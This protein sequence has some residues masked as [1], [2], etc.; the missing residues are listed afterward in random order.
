MPKRVDK[1][2]EQTDVLLVAMRDAWAG[3][4]GTPEEAEDK[5]F[6][7]SIIDRY[8][9]LEAENSDLRSALNITEQERDSLN[10]RIKV[11]QQFALEHSAV[12]VHDA[13]LASVAAMQVME[14][15]VALRE[16]RMALAKRIK[17]NHR[18]PQYVLG[19]TYA[20]EMLER[21]ADRALDTAKVNRCMY[22]H[23]YFALDRSVC[24][25][26]E[27]QEVAP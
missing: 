19:M 6:A 5:S 9:T 1:L 8:R 21:L 12:Q 27:T 13:Q 15:G 14:L 17:D 24:D 4:G 11:L 18:H 16:A 23:H 3:I 22:P 25:C 20:H 26:G 7:Q 2:Y 10:V